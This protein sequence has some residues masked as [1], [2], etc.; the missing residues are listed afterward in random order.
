MVWPLH[1]LPNDY[2]RFT[3]FGLRYL[4]E[5]TGWKIIAISPSNGNCYSFLQLSMVSPRSI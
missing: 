2:Y 1:E 4:L 3:E 5:A